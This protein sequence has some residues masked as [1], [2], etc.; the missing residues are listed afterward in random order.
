M[1]LSVSKYALV[2]NAGRILTSSNVERDVPLIAVPRLL[3]QFHQTKSRNG[4]DTLNHQK[5]LDTIQKIERSN[6]LSFLDLSPQLLAS[7]IVDLW[8]DLASDESRRDFL[9]YHRGW[10]AHVVLLGCLDMTGGEVIERVIEVACC[11][12][13]LCQE[14]QL[15][16]ATVQSLQTEAVSRL[17]AWKGV[18]MALACK[19]QE[20]SDGQL[21]QDVH[22]GTAF[23]A[24]RDML[25]EYWILSRPWG[26][27]EFLLTESLT[28]E[29]EQHREA[30]VEAR[31]TQLED[32]LVKMEYDD[33][34]KVIDE[35]IAQI[36]S[37]LELSEI[38]QITDQDSEIDFTALSSS[39]T[40]A[41]L[42]SDVSQMDDVVHRTRERVSRRLEAMKQEIYERTK[43]KQSSGQPPLT[44]SQRTDSP[45]VFPL[46]RTAIVR[47]TVKQ[48][49]LTNRRSS[50][51]IIFSVDLG[52][53]GSKNSGD[54]TYSRSMQQDLT[55]TSKPTTDYPRTRA[56]VSMFKGRRDPANDVS[57][58]F[59]S[60]SRNV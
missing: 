59:N 28:V 30:D 32:L 15:A 41:T 10:I 49:A 11:L 46:D 1:D 53:S 2:P 23:R 40:D 36:S 51:A 55:P 42:E 37:D 5:E 3:V 13:L 57:N 26:R 9:R 38:E 22:L 45:T 24:P 56:P 4:G 39:D 43:D 34:D 50:S 25:L 31:I 27:N 7:S 12:D 8:R 17:T 54:S 33:V 18:Q 58:P 35:N 52:N 47:A 6:A 44:H 60:R 29:P 20:I 21:A 19:I 14:H 48:G 16:L